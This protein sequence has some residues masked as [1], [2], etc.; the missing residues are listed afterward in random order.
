MIPYFVRLLEI[1]IN[2]GTLPEDWR[3]ATVVPV[4]KGEDRSLVSNYRPVSLNSV[5][6]KQ[7]EHVIASYLRQVWEGNDWLYE[8][9]H[10]FR[11]GYS[12]ESQVITVYQ[13]IADTL[14]K[15]GRM[16]AIIFDFS[17]AFDLVPHGRLLVK[18]ADSGVDNRVVVW[19]R[20]FLIG[21]TQRVRVGGELS[22]EVRVTSGVP[23]G[24][25]LGPLLFLAYV[26]DIGRNIESNIRL[27]ADDC[28]IYREILTKEDMITLQRDVDRLGEWA[29]D[30][31][32]KINPSKSKALCFTRARVKDPLKYSLLGTLVPE[33][34][35]CKYLGII[36]R[37]DLSWADHVNYT[38]KKAWK[39]LHFI[40][41][42]LRKGNS[43][44][45]RL[46]YTSLVRPILEYGAACWDPYREGQIRELDRV[47]KKAAKFSHH[48]KSPTWETLASRRKIA[49]LCALYKAY[50]GER[51]W[52]AIGDRLERPHYLSR[53]DHNLKIRNR[54][55]RT[56]IGKYSFVNRTIEHW[57]QLPAEVL[58]PL[59]C[60]STTF[61]KRI[62]K[63]ISEVR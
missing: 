53:A 51:A 11:P 10:G 41:R 44:T 59:P 36:L 21:R 22:E 31:A 8:V 37:N 3:R 25:V 49:R 5:V 7:M 35:N 9:Q 34:S 43:N 45:K 39:S 30:N 14:D 15:G 1:T 47:Q 6:C 63:V 19:I 40:M 4:H 16:D 12:C 46:A 20:E 56:D 60:N 29:V 23:Q 33:A 26:N 62:R 32:M 55:Q 38:V 18:I 27:F 52:K 61:R 48:T 24:S 28:V 17:K 13:D 42:I 50:R 54:R 57:N 2:N 58:E